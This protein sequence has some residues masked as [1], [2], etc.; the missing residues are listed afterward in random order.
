MRIA[1]FTH[2]LLSDWSHGSAHFLRG[3][4]SELSARGHGVR[5]FEPVDAWSVVNLVAAA[6]EA[7]LERARAAYPAL[8]VTRYS[9]ALDLDEA[10]AGVDLAIV[11]EWNDHMLV[12]DLGRHR[13]RRGG[14]VLLFHDTYHRSVSDRRSMDAYDLSGYDAV[15]AFGRAVRDLYLAN[16]WARRAF[17]FHEGADVRRFRPLPDVG[18]RGD[19]IWVGNWGDDERAAELEEFLIEPV[20]ALRLRARVYG[21]RYPTAAQQALARAGIEYHGWV[22]NFDVPALLAAHRVTVHVPRRPYVRALPGIPTIRPFE[23][24]AAGIPLV[25]APWDDVEGLFTAGEDYLVARSGGQMQRHLRA[26]LDDTAYAS[27][28]AERARRTI[29]ARHSCAHRAA[30]L[31]AIAY[32]LGVV[33]RPRAPGRAIDDRAVAAGGA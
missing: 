10:L 32:E 2:S 26:L 17:V 4:V 28:L 25:S 12:G 3:L 15:L 16:G 9:G 18:K 6:G 31:E 33:E 22:A 11:H 23:A 30:E 14:Y 24:M 5:V 21:A 27:A 7:A 19:L 1:L 29:L 13:R 20:R 8:A